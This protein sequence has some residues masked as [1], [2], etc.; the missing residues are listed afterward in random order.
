MKKTIENCENLCSIQGM[1]TDI[2][3]EDGKV[4]GVK[5]REGV[6]YRAK[7]VIIAT[8]TFMRGLIHIGDKHFSGG[9]MGE[10]SSEDLPLSLEKAGLKL[11]RFKT[12]ATRRI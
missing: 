10:L 12:R 1:V 11:A 2:V 4:I 8:G 7:Y 3:V 9:R 6:E 5:T